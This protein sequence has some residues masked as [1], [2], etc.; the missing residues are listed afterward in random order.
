MFE[1]SQDEEIDGW[2]AGWTRRH[3]PGFPRYIRI[4]E[5]D[6]RPPP[7]GRC[8]RVE[9]NGGAAA[10]YGPSI[11]V[12]PDAQYLLEGY[13]KTSGL[14]HDEAYLSLIFLDLARNKLNSVMAVPRPRVPRSTRRAEDQQRQHVAKG[15]CWSRAAP[16]RCKLDSR[17]STR[18]T[19]G[20]GDRFT[21]DRFFRRLWLGQLPLVVLTAQPAQEMPVASEM[22]IHASRDR[23]SK[24][25]KS[26]PDWTDGKQP[27]R[28]SAN[29]TPVAQESPL[30]QSGNRPFLLFPRGQPIEIACL[31]SGF[32]VPAYD[33]RMELLDVGGRK[34]A[35]HQQSFDSIDFADE[36]PWR[37]P[38][39][40]P[41]FYRVRAL[42][43]PCCPIAPIDSSG[44]P[45]RP[46]AETA[47]EAELSLAVIEP[48]SLPSG[49]EFGWSLNP[50]TPTWA[51]CHLAICF[52]NAASAG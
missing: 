26:N 11:P 5:N 23:P 45:R 36:R 10:A 44:R 38:G 2:P 13:V 17:R 14:Q 4:R 20:R 46:V 22:G 35:E 51:C 47:A 30:P 29:D 25:E 52:A 34:L 1:S 18:G 28:R 3:G 39:D 6:D 15:P 21:R 9:L 48:Q 50:N 12:K 16:G 49:S 42:I 43:V 19:R 31:V 41:G 27:P 40:T 8:L 32:A 33:I 7:G 37:L 24:Q